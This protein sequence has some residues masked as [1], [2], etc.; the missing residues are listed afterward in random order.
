MAKRN[1]LLH[2]AATLLLLAP[3]FALTA[4]SEYAPPGE[5]EWEVVATAEIVAI[6][7]S[8]GTYLSGS[9]RNIES[10]TLIDY[11]YA[12]RLNSGG[13]RQAMVSTFWEDNADWDYP[14]SEAVT[15]HQD[16]DK[17]R[18]DKARIEVLRCNPPEKEVDEDDILTPVFGTH[19]K[20]TMPDGTPMASTE[21]RIDIHVPKGSI[22]DAKS[23]EPE[24]GHEEG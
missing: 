15:I 2:K 24:A 10:K 6:D 11:K 7:G 20:C 17:D 13:V 23:L 22:V 3:M 16:I 12:Y 9:T 18:P 8:T 5:I 21:H 14:G 4:C 19:V 1:S